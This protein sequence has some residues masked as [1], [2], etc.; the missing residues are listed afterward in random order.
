MSEPP[1]F[2]EGVSSIPAL[3]I[4][5]TSLAF[6]ASFLKIASGRTAQNRARIEKDFGLVAPWWWPWLGQRPSVAEWKLDMDTAHAEKREEPT[7]EVW[8]TY[9]RLGQWVTCTGRIAAPV[10]LLTAVVVIVVVL[11]MGSSLLSRD[12][13]TWLKF[14]AVAM[15][16][17]V[18][19]TVFVCLDILRV[20]RVFIRA[21]TKSHKRLP[22]RGNAAGPMRSG[23]IG[24]RRQ[25]ML[26]V[27]AC[28]EALGPIMVLPFIVLLLPVAAANTLSEGWH[29]PWRLIILYGCFTL[30][31]LA[32]ALRFQFEAVR[33]KGRLVRQLE[34]YRHEVLGN[35]TQRE[36]VEV[37]AFVPWSRHP[38]LQS[39][40]AT[41]LAVVTLLAAL[42]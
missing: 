13:H 37:V 22:E 38:I 16:A 6:C 42:L 30:Y 32:S 28:T 20:T 36:R 8:A 29:W 5:L 9:L 14:G 19:W 17:A 35:A 23:V 7:W 2:F 34:E 33:A 27:V 31:V 11:E 41:G 15:T 21:V 26:L 40:G 12:L 24:Q 25:K 4:Q 18:L 1:L 3:I 10:G 39:V